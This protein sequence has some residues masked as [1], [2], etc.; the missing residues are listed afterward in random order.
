MT[1]QSSR[2]F[3]TL[4]DLRDRQELAWQRGER[5]LVESLADAVSAP[6]RDAKLLILITAEVTLR[7]QLGE[8]CTSAEYLQRF[9]QFAEAL[10]IHFASLEAEDM[11]ASL[12]EETHSFIAGGVDQSQTKGNPQ[13]PSRTE[14]GRTNG[15]LDHQARKP[16]SAVVEGMVRDSLAEREEQVDRTTAAD[17]AESRTSALA[18]ERFHRD[19]PACGKCHA[20]VHSGWTESSVACRGTQDRQPGTVAHAYPASR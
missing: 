4:D 10:R 5:L 15:T 16:P 20:A 3:E 18:S 11:K 2:K 13:R 14:A 7:R 17:H 1:D 9:P 6:A 12:S 8:T 19:H